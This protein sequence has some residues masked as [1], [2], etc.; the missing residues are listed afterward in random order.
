MVA[1][2]QSL[3]NEKRN[4]RLIRLGEVMSKTG[5]GRSWIYQSIKNGSF[6]TPIS[7]SG[8]HVVAWVEHE[9]QDWIESRIT[10]SRE[11]A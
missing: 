7:V 10:A 1:T 9:I 6:P 5:M 8:A 4:L 3:C 11:S 2:T